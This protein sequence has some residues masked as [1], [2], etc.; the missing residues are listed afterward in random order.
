MDKLTLGSPL[1]KSM[2]IGAL[3]DPV[4]KQRI[5]GLVNRRA[6]KAA[7]CTSQRANCQPTARGSRRP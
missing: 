7:P 2:D 4:Q 3:V 5:E 6:T 1:D